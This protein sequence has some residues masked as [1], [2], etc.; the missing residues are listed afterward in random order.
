MLAK[1]PKPITVFSTPRERFLAKL[2]SF[3]GHRSFVDSD[4]FIASMDAVKLEYARRLSNNTDLSNAAANGLKLKGAQEFCDLFMTFT[5]EPSA[6]PKPPESDNLK[7]LE[8]RS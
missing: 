7:S 4:L 6:A 8:Q 1:A 2:P 5:E 3:K